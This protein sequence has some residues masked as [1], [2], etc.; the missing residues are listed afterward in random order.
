MSELYNDFVVVFCTA[1]PGDADEIARTLVE[2]RLAACVSIASIRSCYLWEGAIRQDKEELLIIK[3]R[4]ALIEPLKRRI[5]DLNSYSL[6]EMIVLPIIDGYQP[7][8]D[9]IAQSTGGQG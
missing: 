8:L 2:E 5:M 6:P 9:W 3:T 1:A 7:Y 4:K